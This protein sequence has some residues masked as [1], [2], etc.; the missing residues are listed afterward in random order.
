MYM[1]EIDS[2]STVASGLT[3]LLSFHC[4]QANMLTSKINRNNTIIFFFICKT[5]DGGTGAKSELN[6][7][8]YLPFNNLL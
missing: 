6:L 8:Q 4:S 7:N 1:Q 3:G 5:A 2:L